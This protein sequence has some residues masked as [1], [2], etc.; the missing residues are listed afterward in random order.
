MCDTCVSFCFV[1][2]DRGPYINQRGYVAVPYAHEAG[3]ACFAAEKGGSN[4]VKNVV[5]IVLLNRWLGLVWC[6]RQSC[7]EA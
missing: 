2:L 4:I 5:V 7:C 3:S 1:G 6:V